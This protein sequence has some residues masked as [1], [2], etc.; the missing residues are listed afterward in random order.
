MGI[1]AVP[2]LTLEMSITVASVWNLIISRHN[3]LSFTPLV[4]LDDVTGVAKTSSPE[5]GEEGGLVS[6]ESKCGTGGI[7]NKVGSSAIVLIKPRALRCAFSLRSICRAAC[8]RS[9]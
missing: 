6:D 2:G 9:T 1:Q 3:A 8:K 5:E 7:C 4:V